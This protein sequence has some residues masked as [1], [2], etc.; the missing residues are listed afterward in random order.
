LCLTGNY[1]RQLGRAQGGI[2]SPILANMTLDGIEEILLQKYSTS[3]TGRIDKQQN[4]DHVNF[5]RYA[6]DFIV[7]ARTKKTAIEVQKIV[8]VFLKERG[9][10][11]SREKTKITRIEDGFDFLGWNIR[12]Y[13]RGKTCITSGRGR[14]GRKEKKILLMKPSKESLKSIC[15][16]VRGMSTGT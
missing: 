13:K 5:I 14:G 7:T 10:E 2:I 9:L 12:K 11:L 6:D 3:S 1:S 15:D 4:K 8:K 16:K